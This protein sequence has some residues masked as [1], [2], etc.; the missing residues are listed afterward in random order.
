MMGELTHT[1]SMM[2]VFVYRQ[3]AEE[4]MPEGDVKV[5]MEFA[6]D[7]AQAGHRGRGHALHQ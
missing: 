4:P 1:Y 5:R 3:Q 2:G 7:A 6:A